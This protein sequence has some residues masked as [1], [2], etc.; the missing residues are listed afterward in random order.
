LYQGRAAAACY[1]PRRVPTYLRTLLLT[2]PLGEV[3]ALRPGHEAQ[4]RALRDA[5]RLRGAGRFGRGDGYIEIFEARDLMEAE[6]IAGSSPLVEAGLGAW[7]VR[8]LE[9]FEA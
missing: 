6:A 5:G 9:S 8:E 7:S 1:D 4:V 2:G 3:D